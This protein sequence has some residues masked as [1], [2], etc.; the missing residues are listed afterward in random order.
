MKVI[1]LGNNMGQALS[2]VLELQKQTQVFN[3]KELTFSRA[4]AVLEVANPWSYRLDN[5]S[6]RLWREGAA[7]EGW[8][9]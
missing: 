2:M 5:L 7:S 4:Q 1:H 8:A 9:E 6:E 3:L